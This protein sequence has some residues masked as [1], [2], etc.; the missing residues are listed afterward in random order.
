MF[1][2]LC[3][4]TVCSVNDVVVAVGVYELAHV[5][6]NQVGTRFLRLAVNKQQQTA[7]HECLRVRFAPMVST[8]VRSVSE[9][10]YHALR[11]ERSRRARS[12]V[13]IRPGFGRQYYCDPL[14]KTSPWDH[15]F[16]YR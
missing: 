2:Q 3:F 5:K 8:V 10:D 12:P 13:R 15:G 16:G 6:L 11:Y 7:A 14:I 9:Y 4:T 1:V